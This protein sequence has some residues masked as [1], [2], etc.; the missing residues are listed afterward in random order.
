M[1]ESSKSWARTLSS[2]C[3][4]LLGVYL[5]VSPFY[6]AYE[7]R[8]IKDQ[9]EVQKFLKLESALKQ[10]ERKKERVRANTLDLD[11]DLMADTKL[12]TDV[13]EFNSF[14]DSRY[15]KIEKIEADYQRA[16]QE[17]RYSDGVLNFRI[18]QKKMRRDLFSIFPWGVTSLFLSYFLYPKVKKQ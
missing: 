1:N 2:V 13:D 4:G 11:P 3:A 18:A 15:K 9:P 5:I 7:R 14:W 16:Y 17:L 8:Y 10:I 6:R 12:S